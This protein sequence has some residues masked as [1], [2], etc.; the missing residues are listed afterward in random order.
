MNQKSSGPSD[1][2]VGATLTRIERL[3]H[4]YWVLHFGESVLNIEAP[5]RLISHDLILVTR[6][7]DG[8]KFG[9]PMPVDAESELRKR[10]EGHRV[11]AAAANPATSDLK[12]QFD[13]AFTLEV[14]NL[15]SG[16]ECWTLNPKDGSVI[17]GRNG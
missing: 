17:V 8:Q 9:F 16:Y 3:P 12:L 4:N 15:S 10:I 7:D 2:L 11:T 5:W 6:E 1:V 13:N 14:L